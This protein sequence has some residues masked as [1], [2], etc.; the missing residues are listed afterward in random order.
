MGKARCTKLEVI[1]LPLRLV[2]CDGLGSVTGIEL[3]P[4]HATY[5]A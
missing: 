2:A 5:E 3:S 1:L 4:L